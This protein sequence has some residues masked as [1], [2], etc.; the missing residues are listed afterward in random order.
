MNVSDELY[1]DLKK[2]RAVV[3]IDT[4]ACVRVAPVLK[5]VAPVSTVYL[6]VIGTALIP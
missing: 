5:L 2:W 6:V 1:I 3:A 4:E